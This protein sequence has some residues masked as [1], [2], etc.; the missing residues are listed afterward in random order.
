M[1]QTSRKLT[2]GRNWRKN[3]YKLA[4]ATAYWY[5]PLFQCSNAHPSSLLLLKYVRSAFFFSRA[6]K[7]SASIGARPHILCRMGSFKALLS[8]TEA[9]GS[10]LLHTKINTFHEAKWTTKGKARS[11][12]ASPAFFIATYVYNN[13]FYG[14]LNDVQ[15]D[16]VCLLSITI[17]PS[18]QARNYYCSDTK[19][20]ES[21]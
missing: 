21:F 19:E 15:G 7:N 11:R 20:E 5:W 1:L 17:L 8:L 2:T 3:V 4:E 18:E 16:W 10:T 9:N 6:A 12:G 13:S 14:I